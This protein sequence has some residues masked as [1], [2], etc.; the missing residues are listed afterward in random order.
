MSHDTPPTV[1]HRANGSTLGE[2]VTG[3][4]LGASGV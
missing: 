2:A 4:A 1:A 3:S